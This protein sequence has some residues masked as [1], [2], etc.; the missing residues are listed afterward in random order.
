MLVMMHGKGT[1]I[2]CWWECKLVQPLWKPVCSFLKKLKIELPYDLPTPL[3]YTYPKESES[4]YCRD[5]PV[6][7]FTVVL[8]TIAKLWNH[9]RCPSTNDWIKKI[10]YG[11]GLK[12]SNGRIAC[13]ARMRP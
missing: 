6:P 11:A 5:T 9:P 3:L 12:G 2:H 13:L 4:A 10:H 1:L 8:F 7:V